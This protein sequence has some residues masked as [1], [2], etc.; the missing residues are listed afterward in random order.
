MGAGIGDLHAS[1]PWWW[2]FPLD[3]LCLFVI[4]EF[5]NQ[6]ASIDVFLDVF[7]LFL[8]HGTFIVRICNIDVGQDLDATDVQFGEITRESLRFTTVAFTFDIPTEFDV[9]VDEGDGVD[10]SHAAPAGEDLQ[11]LIVVV[12]QSTDWFIEE[13]VA[14]KSE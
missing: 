8:R 5:R 6:R 7:V 1:Y 2:L 3:P 13:Q 10:D 11:R 9:F 12:L 4:L 14:A